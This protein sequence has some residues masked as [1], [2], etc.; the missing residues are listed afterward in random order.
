MMKNMPDGGIIQDMSL[1]DSPVMK[2]AY[3]AQWRTYLMMK[4]MPDE[5]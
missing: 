3:V 2:I 5:A 1:C 4:N